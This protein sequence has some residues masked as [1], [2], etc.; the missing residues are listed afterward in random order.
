MQ[1]CYALPS[2]KQELKQ[3]VSKFEHSTVFAFQASVLVARVQVCH[4]FS[5]LHHSADALRP[6]GPLLNTLACMQMATPFRLRRCAMACASR[7]W[8]YQHILY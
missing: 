7:C 8:Y 2:M 4:A 5:P 6:S 3:Y 1:A